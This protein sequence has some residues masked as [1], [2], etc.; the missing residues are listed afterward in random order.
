MLLIAGRPCLF[1]STEDA[2]RSHILQTI[3]SRFVANTLTMIK[4]GLI[5]D[6]ERFENDATVHRAMQRRLWQMPSATD[7]AG[8]KF[9]VL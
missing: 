7:G 6:M 4:S 3:M 9:L 1:S 2:R 8:G 5:S